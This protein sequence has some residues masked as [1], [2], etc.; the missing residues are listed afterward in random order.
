L[1]DSSIDVDS[2]YCLTDFRE[3]EEEWDRISYKMFWEIANF[4]ESGVCKMESIEYFDR[5]LEESGTVH[6]GETEV[7]F[8]DFV[9]DVLPLIYRLTRASY[10]TSGRAS[11]WS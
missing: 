1:V 8:K 3:R 6:P 4:P 10:I 5:P 7:W 9:Q 11:R 2:Q